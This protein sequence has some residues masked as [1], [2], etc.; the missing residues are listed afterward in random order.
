MTILTR[1]CTFLTFDLAVTFIRSFRRGIHPICPVT[2]CHTPK[3]IS[4]MDAEH[5]QKCHQN[6]FIGVLETMGCRLYWFQMQ[7]KF[8]NLDKN[9]PQEFLKT[10]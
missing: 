8:D 1:E 2:L 5:Q 6:H 10:I 7:C 4:S 3:N 9:K